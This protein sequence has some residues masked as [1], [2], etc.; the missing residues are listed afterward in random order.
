MSEIMF[1]REFML[2]LSKTKNLEQQGIT[3][4]M[5]FVT[6]PGLFW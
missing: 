5:C 4:N 2:R 3:Q 1:I 6:Q